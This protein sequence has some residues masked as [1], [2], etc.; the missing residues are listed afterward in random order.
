[1]ILEVRRRMYPVPLS[2]SDPRSAWERIE[3]DQTVWR[4]NSA[5]D[6]DERG[7]FSYATPEDYTPGL[8]MCYID[9]DKVTLECF[10]AALDRVG[11]LTLGQITRAI[12]ST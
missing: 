8:L 2:L 5:R 12:F 11:S 9:G 7:A 6:V 3:F 4:F 10:A 1:M